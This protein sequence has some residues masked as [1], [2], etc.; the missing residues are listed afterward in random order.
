LALVNPQKASRISSDLP[1]PIPIQPQSSTPKPEIQITEH[2]SAA[3]HS[4]AKQLGDGREEDLLT[5]ILT[6]PSLD[7]LRGCPA[8]ILALIDDFGRSKYLMNVGEH[9]GRIVTGLITAALKPV[10]MLE[11][12]GY[13]G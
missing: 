9:K 7:S 12:G 5:H 13:V 8:R 10:V 4:D 11:L 1:Y 6:H 3:A 2:A